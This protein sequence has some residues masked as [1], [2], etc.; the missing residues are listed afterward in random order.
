MTLVT[1]YI[2]P[3]I[4]IALLFLPLMIGLHF[5][6]CDN[7]CSLKYVFSLRTVQYSSVAG[8]AA[9]F[10]IILDFIGDY[11][12][13]LCHGSFQLLVL[14]LN[15]LLALIIPNLIFLTMNTSSFTY[16][17][18][19]LKAREIFVL[20][21]FL[22]VLNHHGPAVWT[23]RSTSAIIS[24]HNSACI[25]TCVQDFT[26]GPST[27]I[28]I[29]KMALY[30]MSGGWFMILC[31]RWV[32]YV[33]RSNY[34]LAQ[35]SLDELICTLNLS[36]TITAFIGAWLIG[37][38]A[39]SADWAS[40]PYYYFV[41]YTYFQIAVTVMMMMWNGRIERKEALLVKAHHEMETKRMIVRYVSHE[42]RTPLNSVVMGLTL[43]Q[44]KLK[45]IKNNTD[46]LEIVSDIKSSGEASVVILDDLLTYEKLD[47]NIMVIDKVEVQ[48]NEMVITTVKNFGPQVNL[49]KNIFFCIYLYSPFISFG[50][51]VTWLFASFI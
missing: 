34:S 12:T 25:L 43:L 17:V 49:Q 32:G 36:A 4:A 31:Y 5:N 3:T 33:K 37:I 51:F 42:I 16:I 14:K 20:C 27:V 11:Y 46:L 10:P 48:V 8:I 18:P 22:A 21:S 24:L 7:E 41:A 13:K 23:D 26:A 50:F 35:M 15:L 2:L 40:T 38:I 1:Y 9:S 39:S 6:N 45:I 30:C 28:Y 47:A 29:V 44:K 19:I